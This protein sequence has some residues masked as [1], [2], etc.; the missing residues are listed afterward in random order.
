MLLT[1]STKAEHTMA[2]WYTA[3]PRQ[4]E[5][6]VIQSLQNAL[7]GLKPSHKMI[8]TT[9]IPN[10]TT[11]MQCKHCGAAIPVKR[12]AAARDRATEPRYCSKQHQIAA[13]ALRARLK[14]APA[15]SP[16]PAA[17]PDTI[18]VDRLAAM[19]D[20]QLGSDTNTGH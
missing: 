14:A 15:A 13:K 1:A 12:I 20:A 3:T 17:Q 9:S 7:G 11:S 6:Q 19:F 10:Y 18:D 4:D 2:L 5:P 8:D 16:A